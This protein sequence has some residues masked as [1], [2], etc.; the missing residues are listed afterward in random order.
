MKLTYAFSILSTIYANDRFL[1]TS[2]EKGRLL[3]KHQRTLSAFEH[4]GISRHSREYPPPA[5]W[6]AWWG[7]THGHLAPTEVCDVCGGTPGMTK[8]EE[9][10]EPCARWAT[11]HVRCAMGCNSSN[12]FQGFGQCLADCGVTVPDS[13]FCGL[14]TVDRNIGD[15]CYH[16]VTRMS[17]CGCADNLKFHSADEWLTCIHTCV[18]D[19]GPSLRLELDMGFDVKWRDRKCPQLF[20]AC[21]GDVSGECMEVKNCNGNVWD[22]NCIDKVCAPPLGTGIIECFHDDPFCGARASAESV[23]GWIPPGTLQNQCALPRSE[24]APC[25]KYP[26]WELANSYPL[27]AEDLI[28]N[29]DSG[30]CE[31][32][33]PPEEAPEGEKSTEEGEKNEG[34]ESVENTVEGEDASSAENAEGG[35]ES[36]SAEEPPAQAS[37]D[38]AAPAA[39]AAPTAPASPVAPAAPVA[40]AS[41]QAP[42]APVV[43]AAPTTPEEVA[44]NAPVAQEEVAPN[45]PVAQEEAAPAAP[46]ATEDAATAEPVAT[47]GASPAPAAPQEQATATPKASSAVEPGP[48]A[49][50]FLVNTS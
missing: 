50:E 34:S 44:P 1:E 48:N 37:A 26:L 20:F 6:Y 33:P 7:L 18:Y 43:P 28:C 35:E 8:W 2:K 41:L 31:V 4:D 29:E 47:E 42:A 15:Y 40:P 13:A 23:D 5:P 36:A 16:T 32:A 14:E 46:V 17:D 25:A 49:T 3:R 27:C 9:V 10:S 21:A 30:F 38:P 39:L 19:C 24:G 22:Q 45:A 12:R 11:T